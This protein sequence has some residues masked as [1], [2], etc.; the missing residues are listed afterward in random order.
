MN[1]L[2]AFL[3]GAALALFLLDRYIEAT[4]EPPLPYP[5][6]GGMEFV[7]N[8]EGGGETETVTPPWEYEIF[9]N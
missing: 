3:F 7:V 8:Y 6:D 5:C 9:W 4:S 1:R 2:I